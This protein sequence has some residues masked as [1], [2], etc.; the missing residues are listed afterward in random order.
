LVYEDNPDKLE[1]RYSNLIVPMVKAIKDLADENESLKDEIK[2]LK[3]MMLSIKQM[4]EK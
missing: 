3:E 4:M 1:A 2:S